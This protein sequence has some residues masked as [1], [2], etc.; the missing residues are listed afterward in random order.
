[1]RHYV[2]VTIRH[3][4]AQKYR[5]SAALVDGAPAAQ[6]ERNKRQR[7]L[8]HAN[9]GLAAVRPFAM[10]SFRRRGSVDVCSQLRSIHIYTG[11]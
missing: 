4:L 9:A 8:A 10:E 6:A 2:D 11:K 3:P 5:N 7:Y 1:M